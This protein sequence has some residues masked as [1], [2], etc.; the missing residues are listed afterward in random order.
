MSNQYKNTWF[1]QEFS[2]I[3]F[4]IDTYYILTSSS[5]LKDAPSWNFRPDRPSKWHT[6]FWINQ[7]VQNYLK[8]HS[9]NINKKKIQ[10]GR[11]FLSPSALQ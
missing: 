4:I 2:L 3:H 11:K 1:Q 7:V 6:K 10:K 9:N 8:F 5:P